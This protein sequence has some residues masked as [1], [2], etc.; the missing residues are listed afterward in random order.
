MYLCVVQNYWGRGET[1]T[2]AKKN[3]RKAG[4][5]LNRYILYESD[6]PEI[7]VDEMGYICYDRD[8]SYKEIE[9]HPAAK[10]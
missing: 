4:G 6:D 7:F 2:E 5:K 10:K 8:K 1:I 3:A 9:R